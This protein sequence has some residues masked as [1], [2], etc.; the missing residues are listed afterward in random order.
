MNSLVCQSTRFYIVSEMAWKL[1]K[2]Q[3]FSL[4]RQSFFIREVVFFHQGGIVAQFFEVNL[5]LHFFDKNHQFYKRV[6]IQIFLGS[7]FEY[8]IPLFLRNFSNRRGFFG[9][10]ARNGSFDKC[11]PAMGLLE[12]SARNGSFVFHMILLLST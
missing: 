3:S 7:I 11:L 9:K 12:K 5:Q 8:K 10:S 1:L 2:K 6:T 4:G